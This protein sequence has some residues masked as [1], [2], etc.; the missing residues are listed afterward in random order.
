MGLNERKIIL[1]RALGGR[2]WVSGENS[3]G[4]FSFYRE[5]LAL[6]EVFSFPSDF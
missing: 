6:F 3:Q 5:Y 1:H 4:Y 2:K